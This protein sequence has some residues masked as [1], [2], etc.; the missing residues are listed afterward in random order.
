MTNTLAY[1]V[2]PTE[3][4]FVGLRPSRTETLK[5]NIKD[6]IFMKLLNIFLTFWLDKLAWLVHESILHWPVL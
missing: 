5:R 3:K 4:C 2:P 6:I 1:F